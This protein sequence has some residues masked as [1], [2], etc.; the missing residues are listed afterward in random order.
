MPEMLH[1]VWDEADTDDHVRDEG[2][3]L[4]EGVTWQ[5]FFELCRCV[6]HDMV[7]TYLWATCLPA[8]VRPTY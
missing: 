7:F 4:E 3:H 5:L 1:Q 6:C 2:Q 8:L